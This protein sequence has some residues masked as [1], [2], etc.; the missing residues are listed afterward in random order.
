MSGS[1]KTL[2]S[3]AKETL[4]TKIHYDMLG[5]KDFLNE[6][7]IKTSGKLIGID[8]SRRQQKGKG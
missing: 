3:R 8:F 7:S 1:I 4:V 5:T 2:P 6:L